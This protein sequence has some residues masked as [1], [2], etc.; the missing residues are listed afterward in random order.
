MYASHS[1]TE[2]IW[3]FVLGILDLTIYQS[4][5]INQTLITHISLPLVG[6]VLEV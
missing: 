1:I 2:N 3:V 6:V 4:L 5:Y